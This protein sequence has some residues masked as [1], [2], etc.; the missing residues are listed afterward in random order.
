MYLRLSADYM[1]P[2]VTVVGSGPT[3]TV[4]LGVSDALT[5]DLEAWN[6]RY[7]SIIQLSA[8]ARRDPDSVAAIQRLDREGRILASKIAE[9]LSGG[10]KVEYYSDGLFRLIS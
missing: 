5:R 1:N 8:E 3:S 2:V 9:E 6:G 7:Q 10:S 4:S